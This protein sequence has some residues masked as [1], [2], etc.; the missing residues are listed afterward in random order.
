MFLIAEASS[1]QSIRYWPAAPCGWDNRKIGKGVKFHALSH[2]TVGPRR[3]PGERVRRGRVQL[4]RHRGRQRHIGRRGGETLPHYSDDQRER[5]G[6][7]WGAGGGGR[8]Y[9]RSNGRP[10]NS[11]GFTLGPRGGLLFDLSMRGQ[12]LHLCDDRRL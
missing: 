3:R 11:G 9:P 8:L 7:Y 2:F 1:Y 12:R 4:Q 5:H 10:G 6:L